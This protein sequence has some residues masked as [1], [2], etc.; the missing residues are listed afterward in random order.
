MRTKLIV[1]GFL[2]AI[3]VTVAG[4][5]QNPVSVSPVSQQSSKV[6]A[7]MENEY[8][9]ISFVSC[10]RNN[11]KSIAP[12]FELKTA[13]G[14]LQ[15]PVD[16][17]AESYQILTTDPSLEMGL[18]RL[19]HPKWKAVEGVQEKDSEGNTQVIWNAGKSY[20]RIIKKIK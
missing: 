4:N 7:K 6:L 3:L 18:Y 10:K 12:V 13:S 14:W 16:A 8:V 11:K 2:V 5:A 1:L 9:K 15:T 17:S 20:E 19:M